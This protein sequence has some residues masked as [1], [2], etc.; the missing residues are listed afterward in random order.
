MTTFCNQLMFEWIHTWKEQ[1]PHEENFRHAV[2][3]GT[4][5]AFNSHSHQKQPKSA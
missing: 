4:S 3:L 2:V 5:A 1:I